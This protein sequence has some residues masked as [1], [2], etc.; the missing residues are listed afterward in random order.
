MTTG[1]GGGRP[2]R[3]TGR[4]GSGGPVDPRRARPTRPGP[5]SG[6]SAPQ[7]ARPRR[8]R[9][10]GVRPV[11]RPAPT[12]TARPTRSVGSAGRPLRTGHPSAS[13]RGRRAKRARQSSFS[14]ARRGRLALFALVLVL[15]A[16]LVKLTTIQVFDIGNYAAQSAQQRTREIPLIAQR[17][18]ITDVN[19][20]NVAFTVEGR[21]I[22]ARPKLFTDDAQRQAVARIIV[23]G[24]AQGGAPD[25]ASTGAPVTEADILEK[26]QSSRT[27]VYLARN[28]LPEQ[29]AAMMK[30]ISPL[31]DQA[32]I[33]A[34]A[35]ER[36][37]MREY[38]DNSAMAAIVGNTDYDGN[39]LSGIESKWD[40]R[41]A[42]KDGTRTV[43][44]DATHLVIPNSTRD[45]V[46]AVD[47]MDV[48][49]TIDSDLQYA[50]MQQLQK[51]V[52]ASQAKK[53]CIVV[54]AVKDAHIPVMACYQPGQ[55]TRQTGNLAATAAFEMGSVNKV[56]TMA[57]ALDK[58]LITPTTPF[59]VDGSIE[60]GGITVK[61]AWAHG[62]T[63]M[64]ATGILAKS[65]N[66]GTLM[67]AQQVGQDDFMAMAKRFGQGA[68]TGVQLPAETSGNLPAMST[69]SA[70]TFANLPI[71]QGVSYNLVE[72]AS[73]YQTIANGG[74]RVQPTLVASTTSDGVTT[75]FPTGTT[76]QVMKPESAAT[77][78]Q[79]L[80]GTIQSGDTAHRGTAPQAQITGY[81]V[82]GKTG[83]AQ[84][85]D[86][87]TGEYSQSLIT[88]TFGGIVPAD[89]PQ[90]AISI[91]LDNPRGDSSVG[92]TSCAPL[93]HDVASYVLRAG[94]VPPSAT[95]APVYDLDLP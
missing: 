9:T 74:V 16:A 63:T 82:A 25:V 59:T 8:I 81:Q 30:E 49:L 23:A 58:G 89:N 64:T 75:P 12:A 6:S 48:Q 91:M 31:F 34:V 39:G 55:T 73:M 40:T 68:R 22:A 5:V 92:T 86:E 69:W 41:L 15:V 71:G 53:G 10:D 26:L 88:S 93:F 45:Q 54:M 7:S 46:P 76:T 24:L 50:V 78:L 66:V 84:Q 13:V 17:G 44:V 21:A 60:M 33:N 14:P 35:T 56:V 28:L 19:G 90:Y 4:V 37:D 94:D 43:D 70:A 36:Q 72:L 79:M 80:R 1:I 20:N 95:P 62:P 87:D 42:G 52:D 32:H 67:I 38:P 27:Y 61:D 3:D 77:L 65:S 47:G 57:A 85:V 83:T 29:A 51:Y 18:T 11:D 2:A